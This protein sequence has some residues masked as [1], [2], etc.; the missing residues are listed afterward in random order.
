MNG[1]FEN[2][3]FDL[4][5]IDNNFKD[6]YECKLALQRSFCEKLIFR[7]FQK[8][9]IVNYPIYPIWPQIQKFLKLH[10]WPF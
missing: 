2:E 3:N 9:F 6:V 10:F 4:I 8:I 1:V 5:P 7:V